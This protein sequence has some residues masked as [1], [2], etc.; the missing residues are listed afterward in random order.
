MGAQ[1][2]RPGD[3]SPAGGAG[4]LAV[5]APPSIT[6]S[7]L[8]D[9]VVARLRQRAGPVRLLDAGCGDGAL[10]EFLGHGLEQAFPGRRFEL[11]GF[12]VANHGVQPTGYFAATRE[13]LA[14]QLPG[15][16][17]SEHLALI[18][19]RDPW[20]WPRASFD[21]VVSNQVLEHVRDHRLFFAELARTLAPDGF[22]VHV[23]PTRHCLVEPHFHIPL[24]HRIGH[25]GLARRYVELAARLGLGRF[26][27]ATETRA[28][29]AQRVTRYLAENT[30]YRSVPELQQLAAQC[31]LRAS[32]ADTGALYFAKARSLA[33]ASRRSSHRDGAALQPA[34]NGAALPWRYV[35]S[36]TLV[37]A[38]AAA[39]GALG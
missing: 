37:L 11:Y 39:P 38:P 5:C 3:S 29:F 15:R 25:G 22:S 19:D 8:L 31:G 18:S 27:A 23:F 10:L 1:Q 28:D 6:H 32:F 21:V 36:V 34:R 16:P 20:P 35:A 9:C 2:R 13:R 4:A 7:H 30:N 24:V 14:A 26:D 33:G 17:W 12:D